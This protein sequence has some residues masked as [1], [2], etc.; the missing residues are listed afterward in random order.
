MPI[1]MPMYIITR[2]AGTYFVHREKINDVVDFPVT[3]LDLRQYVKYKNNFTS[4]SSCDTTAGSNSDNSTAS[5]CS[6]YIYDL[7]AV[8]EHGGGLGGGHYTAQCMNF[9]NQTWY[10]FNDSMVT[11]IKTTAVGVNEQ[12]VVDPEAAA[13]REKELKSHVVTSQAYVLF[14]KRRHGHLRWGGIDVTQPTAPANAAIYAAN[15]MD[16][17][18]SEGDDDSNSDKTTKAMT[19]STTTMNAA[20]TSSAANSRSLQSVFDGSSDL[21]SFGFGFAT[22]NNG[23][24]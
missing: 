9:S 19:S 2:T 3:G 23:V 22:N 18:S 15:S 14:Y 4:N 11:E 21:A 20:R 16:H 6:P 8:S 10:D 17:V 24:L 1:Y 5:D 13:V 12:G 7:Y